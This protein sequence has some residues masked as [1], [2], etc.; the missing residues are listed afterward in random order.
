MFLTAFF[1][2]VQASTGGGGWPMSVFLTPN[3]KPIFGGTYFPP[4]DMMYGR[5]GNE[6]NRSE[7]LSVFLVKFSFS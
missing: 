5:P 2:F 1:N 6:I 3:L 7:L 4:E